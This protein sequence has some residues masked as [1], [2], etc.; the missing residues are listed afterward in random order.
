MNILKTPKTVIRMTSEA[1]MS[2]A[3]LV[4]L[5]TEVCGTVLV[6]FMLYL[7]WHRDENL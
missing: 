5:V 1:G 3:T 2:E 4:Q 7:V 6:M